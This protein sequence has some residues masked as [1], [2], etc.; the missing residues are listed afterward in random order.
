MKMY[1]NFK[2]E[3]F[4]THYYMIENLHATNEHRKLNDEY[5]LGIRYV[6]IPDVYKDLPELYVKRII[7]RIYEQYHY[8]REQELI[9]LEISLDKYL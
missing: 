7:D 2:Y 8:H 5:P 6:S 1:R 4:G 9:L 3:A